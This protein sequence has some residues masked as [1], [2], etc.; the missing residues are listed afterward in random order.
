MLKLIN[1]DSETVLKKDHPTPQARIESELAK[2]VN[3][4]NLECAYLFSTE[5]LLLAG[6][7]GRSDFSQNQ[8]LEIVYSVHDALK[9]FQESPSFQGI[10]EI[11]IVSQS[12]QKISV[13]TFEAFSQP[14]SL[15]LL[16][17][18]G[19]TYRS[20]ANRLIRTIQMISQSEL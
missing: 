12:R 8:A 4:G 3:L 11:L 15:V 7:Q 6:V 9:F 5:G 13:R 16:V 17:P 18:R 14:I 1:R 20:H 2:V 10:Y 19:K